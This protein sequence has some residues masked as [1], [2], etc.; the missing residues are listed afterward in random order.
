MLMFCCFW[1]SF[2]MLLSLSSLSLHIPTSTSIVVTHLSY[3]WILWVCNADVFYLTFSWVEVSHVCVQAWMLQN[4]LNQ[5]VKGLIVV[6]LKLKSTGRSINGACQQKVF[7]FLWVFCF[8]LLSF[9]WASW[10]ILGA[11]SCGETS[12]ILSWLSWTFSLW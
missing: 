3:L 6:W 10:K 11:I 8:S 7:L 9:F 4:R 5:K 1:W 12:N 2:T